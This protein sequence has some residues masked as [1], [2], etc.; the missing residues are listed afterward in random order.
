MELPAEIR[1]MIYSIALTDASGINLVGTFKH[2]RRTVERVSEE[3]MEKVSGA[4]YYSASRLNKYSRA[5][6]TEPESLAASLLAVNKQI[7]QEGRDILYGNEFIFSDSFGLYSF[8]TN[9]GPVRCQYLKTIRLLGWGFGRAM[10]AYNHAC[11]A[12]LVSATNITAFH[13]KMHAG[14]L[15]EP[16]RAAEQLYRDAFLWM[17]AIGAA[18]GR[19][20]A[21]IDVLQLGELFFFYK[22][23]PQD[24]QPLVE[25][26]AA[27]SEFNAALRELLN[28]QHNRVM[29]SRVKRSKKTSKS[30]ASKDI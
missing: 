24:Q 20:D 7:Y 29:G 5:T 14:Y 30:V 21:V 9:L 1:N 18:T 2:K 28:A 19:P 6:S 13:I 16:K 4:N 23:R 27:L 22:E 15:R 26:N 25:F 10:K 17:E 11:F 3:T 8:L 12:A